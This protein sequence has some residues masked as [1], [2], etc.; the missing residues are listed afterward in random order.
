NI[1][2]T[3]NLDCRI[4]LKLLS[5]HA[6][7]IEYNP[8]RFGA[9]VVRVRDPRTTALIWANGKMTLTGAKTVELAHYAARKHARII[10]K[11]GF[12]TKFKDFKVVN[13]VGTATLPFGI[14]LEG[15]VANYHNFAF[16]EPELFPGLV[17]RSI[18]PKCTFLVFYNGKIVLTGAATVDDLYDAWQRFYP[19]LLDY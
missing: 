3:V 7:N 14:R 2:A 6:R 4:D 11:M 8:K 18:T 10:Q 5:K 16:Y 15:L 17:F 12:N 1:I 19:I 13:V 9:A